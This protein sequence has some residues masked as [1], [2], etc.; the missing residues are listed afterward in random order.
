VKKVKFLDWD[1]PHRRAG[2]Q[3]GREIEED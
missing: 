2:R 3:A 1:S